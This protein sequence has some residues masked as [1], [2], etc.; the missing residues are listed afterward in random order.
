MTL[1]KTLKSQSQPTWLHG[2]PEDFGSASRRHPQGR[3][4]HAVAQISNSTVPKT[5]PKSAGKRKRDSVNDE[6]G[7]EKNGTKRKVEQD[8]AQNEKRQRKFACPFYKKSPEI[9]GTNASCL[10]PGFITISRLK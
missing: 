6:A 3:S 10:Y 8:P 1:A 7:H 2:D 5:L 9:H 4:T